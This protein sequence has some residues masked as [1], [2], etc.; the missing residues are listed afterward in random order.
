MWIA[1]EIGCRLKAKI[2]IFN[3][4][5]GRVRIDNLKK[6]VNSNLVFMGRARG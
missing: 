5:G 6:V 3:F 2:F 4:N 1:R